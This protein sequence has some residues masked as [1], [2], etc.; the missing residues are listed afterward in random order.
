MG[1]SETETLNR[2]ITGEPAWIEQTRDSQEP[3]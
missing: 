2:L 1:S 3:P